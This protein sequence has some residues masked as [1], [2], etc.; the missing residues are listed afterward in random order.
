M[1]HLQEPWK[2]TKQINSIIEDLNR[3]QN[4]V[5]FYLLSKNNNIIDSL[6]SG[7]GSLQKFIVVAIFAN[8]TVYGRSN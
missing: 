1:L 3:Q 4:E 2:D 5:S 6:K 7:Y 8:Q